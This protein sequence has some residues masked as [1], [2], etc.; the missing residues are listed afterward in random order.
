M[1]TI[2]SPTPVTKIG[3]PKNGPLGLILAEMLPKLVPP[4]PNDF[5]AM[6]NRS[7]GTS[8]GSKSKSGPQLPK[9]VPH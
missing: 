7:G 1:H 5:A 3:P 8:F 6:Q 4:G 9:L 2:H